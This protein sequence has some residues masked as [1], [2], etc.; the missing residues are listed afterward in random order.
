[1]FY[2]GIRCYYCGGDTSSDCHKGNTAKIPSADCNRNNITSNYI[3]PLP[4]GQNYTM[5]IKLTGTVNGET[6]TIRGCAN[7]QLM[8]SDKALELRASVQGLKTYKCFAD[9]CNSAVGKYDYRSII[10]YIIAHQLLNAQNI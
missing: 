9:L 7:E 8:A 5:C 2:I 4:A 1:M 3:P 6:G 10:Q